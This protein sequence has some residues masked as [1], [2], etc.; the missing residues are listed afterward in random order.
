MGRG[1]S[2]LVRLKEKKERDFGGAKI[3]YPDENTGLENFV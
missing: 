2:S 1:F 3:Q